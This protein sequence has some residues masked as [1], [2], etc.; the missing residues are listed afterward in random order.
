M[1]LSVLE[2]GLTATF[3]RKKKTPEKA[4]NFGKKA[5]NINFREKRNFFSI[6]QNIY[7]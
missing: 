4:T 3:L 2:P 1:D 5:P 6:G 7:F